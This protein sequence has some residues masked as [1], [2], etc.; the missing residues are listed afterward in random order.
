MIEGFKKH[1]RERNPLEKEIHDKFLTDHNAANQINDM[2][3]IVFGHDSD[4]YPLD[5]LSDRERRIVV[6]TIQWL[7]S[8]VGQC[9]LADCGFK[10]K[11]NGKES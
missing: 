3:I 2:D 7:G 6:S 9:F 8:P 1:R 4:L 11:M 10:L 5:K